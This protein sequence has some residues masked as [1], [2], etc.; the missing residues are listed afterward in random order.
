MTDTRIP[1][2]VR[3]PADPGALAAR[4]Q[5]LDGRLV[6]LDF[7]GVLAPLVDR[8]DDAR[9]SP[10]ALEAI[11]AL[12]GR[13]TVAVV[14]GRPLADLRPRLG[15]RPVILAGAHGV[16]I[17][18]ADGHV[19]HLVHA[20]EV[21]G[22]LD[23]AAAAIERLL[24][25]APGWFVERKPTAIAVHH[26]L[27]ADDDVDERLPRVQATMEH[28]RARPPGFEV[29]HG[30][31]VIELRPGGVDKGAA[32]VRILAGSGSREPI[33][34]GDDITDEDAFRAVGDHRGVAILVADEPRPTAADARLID[35]TAVVSFLAALVPPES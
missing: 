3:E 25:D 33:V 13:C 5:P 29:L 27:V 22:T 32:L 23:E 12:L 9:P 16:E 14:S 28:L 7:D 19:E 18:H 8:P 21:V 15:G 24:E 1:E 11:D 10:G 2:G 6:V 35:P 26:R 17:E 34:L 4:L 20:A 30:K 31:A